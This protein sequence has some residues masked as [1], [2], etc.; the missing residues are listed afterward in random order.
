M[1][2]RVS[3][4][5][6]SIQSDNSSHSGCRHEHTTTRDDCAYANA[7][8]N[9]REYGYTH[10]NRDTSSHLHANTDPYAAANADTKSD[11][12]AATAAGRSSMLDF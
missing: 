8:P 2:C 1:Y 9:G 3:E 4:A 7:S 10:P 5:N 11:K 12:A 6:A